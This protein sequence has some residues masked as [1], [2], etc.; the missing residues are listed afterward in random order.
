ME[1]NKENGI[2]TVGKHNLQAQSKSKEENEANMCT[3]IHL[4]APQTTKMKT[5]WKQSCV[6]LSD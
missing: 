4:K 2:A 1:H 3:L 5:K 6:D